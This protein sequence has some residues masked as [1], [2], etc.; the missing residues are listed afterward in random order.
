MS[1]EILGDI[2]SLPAAA[3]LSGSQYLAIAVNSSGQAAVAGAGVQAAGVLVNKPD[4]AGKA[5]SVQYS[6]RTKFIA[7]TGG[8]SAGDVLE[9]E[10]GGD[11]ITLSAGVAVGIALEDVSAAAIGSMLLL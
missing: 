6:G 1:K 10:A 7:G 5:A 9:V 2:L 3:D 8:V 4:A 11:L